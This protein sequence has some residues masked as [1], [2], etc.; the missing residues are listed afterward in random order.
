MARVARARTPSPHLLFPNGLGEARVKHGDSQKDLAR[1]LE[2]QSRVYVAQWEA[3]TS[4]PTPEHLERLKDRYGE[5]SP[6]FYPKWI[7]DI[8]LMVGTEEERHGEPGA[9]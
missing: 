4:L 7:V 8:M 2:L 5:E 3:G 1:E 9:R 6:D